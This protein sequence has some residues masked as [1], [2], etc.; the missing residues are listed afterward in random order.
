MPKDA[1]E[2]TASEHSF[3]NLQLLAVGTVLL[4]VILVV[5]FTSDKKSESSTKCGPYRNDKTVQIES[6]KI[7]TEVASNPTEHEKGLS[8][9]P[10]IEP[11]QGMLFVF[12][13]AGHY[14]F[15]M[16]DMNFPIDIVWIGADHK[17]VGIDTNL[18][19]SSYPDKYVSSKPSKY[20]LELQANRSSSLHINLGTSVNF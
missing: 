13:K 5:V 14:P 6:E 1:K 4:A 2:K 20:I 10:C 19:P 9:R 3:R 18:A 15:W 12:D 11:N 7:R 17:V 8:G 16:K